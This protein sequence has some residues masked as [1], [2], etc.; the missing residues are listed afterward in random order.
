MVLNLITHAYTR[1]SMYKTWIETETVANIVDNSSPVFGVN[2][3][4]VMALVHSLPHSVM[5]FFLLQT[6]FS[7]N[8]EQKKSIK[9]NNKQL[10]PYNVLLPQ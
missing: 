1:R 10:N 8:T 9:G 3:P 4:V 5:L 7:V 2:D 6:A